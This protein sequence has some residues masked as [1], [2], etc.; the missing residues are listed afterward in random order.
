MSVDEIEKAIAELPSKERARLRAWFDAFD[1]DKWD[2][3]I[4]AD[5]KAGHSRKL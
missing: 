3:Q 4:E 2:E 5:I 1:C